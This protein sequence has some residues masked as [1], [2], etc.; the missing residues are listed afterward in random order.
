MPLSF[1]FEH[2]SGRNIFL[3]SALCVSNC[4][5]MG[6][7]PQHVGPQFVCTCPST[8]W[9]QTACLPQCALR[10]DQPVTT[11]RDRTGVG[12]PT[13]FPTVEYWYQRGQ[14]GPLQVYYCVR[15]TECRFSAAFSATVNIMWVFCFASTIVLLLLVEIICSPCTTLIP[16]I[17]AFPHEPS[18]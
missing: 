2:I 15:P 9:G 14:A 12:G 8:S 4:V 17:A 16:Y 6:R 13:N 18:R 5:P 11:V 10:Q 3:R 1:F 7:V